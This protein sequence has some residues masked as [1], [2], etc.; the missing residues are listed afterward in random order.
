MVHK[1]ETDFVSPAFD[2]WLVRDD[3]QASP[4][5]A[6]DLRERV[7]RPHTPADLEDQIDALLAMD[8]GLPPTSLLASIR[9]RLP[10]RKQQRVRIR[11]LVPLAAAATLL[12]GVST[13]FWS[14]Q[15]PSEELS[16]V[17]SNRQVEAGAPAQTDA[18]LTAIIALASN[19]KADLDL[20]TMGNPEPLA[21]LLD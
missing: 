12:L 2:D 10:A 21:L 16:L 6:R 19:L 1:P 8:P 3:V 17:Q 20:S 4:Q 7:R 11:R 14:V 15:S 9:S 18:D 5:L 13:V